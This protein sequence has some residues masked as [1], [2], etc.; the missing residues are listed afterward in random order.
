MKIWNSYGSEHSA[1]LV[2]IGKFT[3]AASAEA[4]KD[5]IDEVEKFI[6]D[7]DSREGAERYSDAEMDLFKRLNFYWLQPGELEQ[8]RYDI[9]SELQ[10]DSIVV[11]TDETEIAALLK[12]LLAKGARVEV[13]SAHQYPDTGKGR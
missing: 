3:D 8:F 13:Y 5:A 1:N 6:G 4:A 9:R 10:G 2:M 12:L 11:T 7:H